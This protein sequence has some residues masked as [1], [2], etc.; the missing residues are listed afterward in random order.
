M[1]ASLTEPDV[2]GR[3]EKRLLIDGQWRQAAGGGTFP[4]EDP[5][6]GRTL[7]EVSD[8]TPDDATAAL[9]AA[10]RAQATWAAVPP[11][12]RGEILRRAYDLLIARKDEFALLITLEMGKSL[13]ESRAEVDYGANYL[14]W[15]GEEAVRID[16]SW[17]VSEDGTARVLV[18]R[19]PVG[20]CLLITPWNAPLAM[21]ARKIGPAVAAGCT[22]I[23]KPAPQAPLT[24]AALAEVLA[25]AG[26]P[27]GVLNIIPTTNA[28]A[29][30]EPLLR[31]GRLR[32]LSFTG[33][34]PVGRLLLGQAAG[35]VLRVS[36]ELGG[37]AP[38]IVCQDADLDAAVEGAM[39]AKLRNIG[40]AC[41]AANRFHVHAA[42]AEEFSEKLVARMTTLALGPGTDP[43]TDLGPLIDEGQRRKVAE[44]VDETVAAGARVRTGGFVP[45]GPGY[46]YPPTVL[47]DVP[48]GSRITRE[49][50]FGPVAAIQTFTTEAEVLRDANNTEFGLVSYLYTRDLSQ[51]LRMSEQLE[52]GM[53]GLN[54]GYVS[55]PSAPFGGMKQSGIGREG[56]GTGIDEYLEQKYVAIDARPAASGAPR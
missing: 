32:K 11:R 28:A 21:P 39:T 49:E 50:I 31:D 27:D 5:A 25:E 20:P 18:M 23:V 13:S 48:A 17:K 36:M 55:D 54:R 10:D 43:G 41:I 26:L 33:S 4:V 3:V 42:V 14:R 30:T 15:F 56:G 16:G 40:E 2:V 46:F 7:C 38:F 34:T 8:G 29:V 45:A 22:M 52:T 9:D 1:V 44:L 51:A 53:V 24:T 6:T 47:T 37:N 12:R 35:T 19:Q